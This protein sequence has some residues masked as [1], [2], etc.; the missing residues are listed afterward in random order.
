MQHFCWIF[1]TLLWIHLPT[2]SHLKNVLFVT[3]ITTCSVFRRLSIYTVKPA[4]CTR[5]IKTIKA[6]HCSH[7]QYFS[8]VP[9]DW[10]RLSIE[11]PALSFLFKLTLHQSALN[12]CS[13]IDMGVHMTACACLHR[14][15]LCYVPT[16]PLWIMWMTWLC[17]TGESDIYQDLNAHTHVRFCYRSEDIS[18]T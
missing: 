13:I 1:V 15:C 9:F 6:A 3:Y 2:S 8:Q 17:G 5:S 18:L 11:E 12:Q 14:L 10:L 7:C 4:T 16:V